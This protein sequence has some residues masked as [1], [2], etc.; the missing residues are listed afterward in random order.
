M[1]NGKCWT[2]RELDEYRKGFGSV[3]SE[4]AEQIVEE[5]L[6]Y[7]VSAQLEQE[8]FERELD[9]EFKP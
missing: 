9:R 3:T 2:M 4:H 1:S 5:F 6:G 7:L 8:R